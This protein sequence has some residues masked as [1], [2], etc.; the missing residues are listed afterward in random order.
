LQATFHIIS[1]SVEFTLAVGEKLGSLLTSGIF[2]ALVGD[3][4][5]GKTVFVQGLAKGLE[6]SEKYYITSPTYTLINEYPGRLP[7]FHVDLYRLEGSDDVET[8]G[9]WDDFCE[10]AVFAVEWADKL[11]GMAWS[12]WLCLQFRIVDDR[13][14]EIVVTAGTPA[15]RVI[16]EKLEKHV[17]ELKWG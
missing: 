11:H 13:I 9:L 12:E 14:R 6:V 5:A 4:G 15:S 1:P 16:L 7:L 10:N 2:L 3:L 8:I 17:K